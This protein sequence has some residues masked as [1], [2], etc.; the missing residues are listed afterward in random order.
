MVHVYLCCVYYTQSMIDPQSV[1]GIVQSLTGVIWRFLF[2]ASRKLQ[3]QGAG[4]RGETSAVSI[5]K[6]LFCGEDC[7]H[8]SGQAAY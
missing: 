6:L 4:L 2:V 7:F 8:K 5:Q 1:C 3:D